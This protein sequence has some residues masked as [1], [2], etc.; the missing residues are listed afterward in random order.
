MKL[1]FKIFLLSFLSLFLFF[2]TINAENTADST[3]FAG[4]NFSLEGA[5][6]LFEEAKSL[7]DFEKALNSKENNVNNLDLNEDG[8]IDYIRVIDHMDEDVHAIVLQA[9]ISADESQDI[10]V[11]EIEKTGK[12]EAT[13]QIIGDEDVYGEQKIVEPFEVKEEQIGKGPSADLKVTRVVFNVWLWPSVRYVYSPRYTLYVSP[14]GWRAYPKYWKPWRPHPWRYHHSHRV[15]RPHFHV[16][17]THRVVRAHKVYS[18]QRRS[19]TTVRTRTTVVRNKNGKVVGAKRTKTKTVRGKNGKVK[20]QKSTTR[21]AG[22]TKNGKV[23]G[24]KK[25]TTVKKSGKK[26]KAKGKKTKKTV[27]KKRG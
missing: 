21:A 7:E 15:H 11:I 5:L 24:K 19:S 26:G 20:A 9:P 18:P 1:K 27:R 14:W 8:E 2:N 23:A 12:D 25:T 17:H 22:K 6:S 10:A 16:V 4:D 3:G 13:L